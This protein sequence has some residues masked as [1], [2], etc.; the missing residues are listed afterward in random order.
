MIIE[1]CYKNILKELFTISPGRNLHE[2]KNTVENKINF[3]IIKAFKNNNKK[4]FKK[5][6]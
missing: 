5:Q 3:Y 2:K 6:L 1:G 4:I